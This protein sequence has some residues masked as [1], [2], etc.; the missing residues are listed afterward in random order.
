MDVRAV[1][2]G[3]ET[4]KVAKKILVAADAAG[5]AKDKII[6]LGEMDGLPGTAD[7]E[8]LFTV[9][10]YLWLYNRSGL[11]TVQEADLPPTGEPILRRIAVAQGEFDHAIVA[12]QLT[13]D[14][15][16]FFAQADGETLDRFEQLF[17]KLPV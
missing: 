9:K 5:V 6:V 13:A 8:D 2:D 12:H 4:T 17:T 10:D 1:I 3:A 14:L 11:P 7:I 16:E 15:A